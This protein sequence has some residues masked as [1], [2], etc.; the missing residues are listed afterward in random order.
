MESDQSK[1]ILV[2]L[3]NRDLAHVAYQSRSV[4]VRINVKDNIIHVL[5]SF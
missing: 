5:T 3:W 1:I 4:E 2:G